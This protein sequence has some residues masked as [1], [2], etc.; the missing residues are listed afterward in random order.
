MPSK[1]ELDKLK[2]T[3][4]QQKALDQILDFVSDDNDRVFILKGYAGTGKTTLMRFLI[5][6][7]K[8][9]KRSF[10]LLAP[11]GRAAKV[12]SNISG[13][14]AQTIHSLIYSFSRLNKDLSDVKESEMNI[15]S[16]GQLYLNFEPVKYDECLPTMV[17]IIDEASMVSDVEEKNVTQA[18]FGSGKLLSELLNYDDRPES[19][20]IFVGDP[21]QLPPVH[22]IQSPALMSSYFSRQYN[23]S[24]RG[25]ELTEIM[26]QKNENDLIVAS[27]QIRKIWALVPENERQYVFP[28]WGRFPLRYNK[29]TQLHEDLDSMV[30]SYI[31]NIKKEGY[32]DSIFIC[33]SNKKCSEIS[34]AVRRALNLTEAYVQKGDLLMVIQNNLPT[35]LMNG[36][37]VEVVHIDSKD[38]IRAGLVF[39]TVVL[40]ELFTGDLKQVLL[41]CTTLINGVLNLDAHQQTELFL[42]FVKRMKK[43][44]IDQ[45]KNIEEFNRAMME[46]PYL[47]ALRCMYG[48]A[49]TCHKSQGGEWNNVYVDF[50]NMA[51]NLT[52]SKMQWVYTAVTRAK[53]TLHTLDK[54]YIQ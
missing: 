32:N 23:M 51:R 37:M 16:T 38:V 39:R 17:Y 21:C 8:K 13:S 5:A 36:D 28:S 20:F 25:A 48:Y 40:R 34:S 54:F 6:K 2:L 52:K 9:D 33:Q 49:V 35:G 47:N 10:M 53:K 46:D 15:D 7:L 41:L 27:L 1:S 14:F 42:D 3:V 22:E 29:N 30:Q 43:K 19:K 11:T 4:S 31:E 18:K 24:S 26:R 12:L 44:G 50:G 45:K